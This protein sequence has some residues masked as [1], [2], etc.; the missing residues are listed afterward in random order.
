MMIISVLIF[1]LPEC[2]ESVVK[3]FRGRCNFVFRKRERIER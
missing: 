2:V 3:E 1:V